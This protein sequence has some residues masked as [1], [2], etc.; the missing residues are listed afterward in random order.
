[1]IAALHPGCRL[2]P[3]G[4]EAIAVRKVAAARR[5]RPQKPSDTILNAMCLLCRSA[6]RVPICSVEP[7]GQIPTAAS[8][9]AEGAGECCD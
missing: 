2:T 1:M 9:C 7:S 8:Q 6:S 4:A 3:V 5:R